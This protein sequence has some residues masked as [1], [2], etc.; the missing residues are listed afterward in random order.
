MHFSIPYLVDNDA[1]GNVT[2]TEFLSY[3]NF[4]RGGKATK[5]SPLEAAAIKHFRSYVFAP[6]KYLLNVSWL[7]LNRFDADGN[8]VLTIDEARKPAKK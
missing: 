4:T 8:G 1:S 3:V 7:T 5:G 6:L 2:L